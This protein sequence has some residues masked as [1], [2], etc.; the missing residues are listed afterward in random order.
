MVIR[1]CRSGHSAL[2]QLSKQRPNRIG[3]TRLTSV[4][5]QRTHGR[6]MILRVRNGNRLMFAT[7]RRNEF[8]K[9]L[10]AAMH[11]GKQHVIIRVS[12]LSNAI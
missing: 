12:Q 3:S 8:C 10:A 1:S 2:I 7:E 6:V 11:T 4:C 5:S 9:E